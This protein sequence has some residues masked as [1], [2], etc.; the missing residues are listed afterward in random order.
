MSSIDPAS[1]DLERDE[2]TRAMRTPA[3]R[4]RSALNVPFSV[5]AALVL[6]FLVS[7][8]N[9]VN[10]HVDKE[11]VALDAQVLAKLMVIG[12]AGLYGMAGAINDVRVRHILFSLPVFL[13][14]V[15]VALYFLSSFASISKEHSMVSTISLVSVL[16]MTVTAM[17]QLG[18]VRFLTTVFHA[19]SAFVVL[20]WVAYFLWPDVGVFMEPTTEG[21]FV[22][23][24]S[25][26]AHS[27]T[28]GQYSGLTVIV[29]VALYHFYGQRS[30]WRLIVIGLAVGALL[31]S[32]SRT[33]VVATVAGLIVMYHRSVF[34]PNNRKWFIIGGMFLA[35]M[36]AVVATQV[37]LGEV[38]AEKLTVVSKSGDAE[39]LT[40]ATGRAEIWQYSLFL[41]AKQPLTGY[42]AAT[43]KY[44]LEEHSMYTHNLL[45]NIAFST[46]ILGGLVGLVMILQQAISAIWKPHVVTSAVIAFIL[47]NGL[48][49]NVIFSIIAGMPTLLWLMSMAWFQV[50]QFNGDEYLAKPL[51]PEDFFK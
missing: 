42:G 15:L 13:V 12:C 11:G 50:R 35:M 43:S 25:G 16:L 3:E 21:E 2:L 26:L 8:L 27:N 28:L 22:R 44:F 30:T 47:V 37:D 9:L 4:L 45:L 7:F 23:R 18:L 14:V 5:V 1:L 32:L 41:I 31:A 17:M 48:F 34:T 36:V 10:L 46:G 33:S 38:I 20:S 24:M 6:V 29:G 19:M 40:S 51:S 39:E 49:E